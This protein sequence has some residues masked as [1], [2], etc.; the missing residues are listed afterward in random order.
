MLALLVL[1]ELVL[2]PSSLPLPLTWLNWPFEAVVVGQEEEKWI[3]SPLACSCTRSIDFPGACATSKSCM[4]GE[5]ETGSTR[6]RAA[7]VA[8]GGEQ[9]DN[10]APALLVVVNITAVGVVP[11]PLIPKSIP[12]IGDVALGI[13]EGGEQDEVDEEEDD[14]ERKVLSFMV[15]KEDDGEEDV[16]E[17]GLGDEIGQGE[18][19]NREPPL[20][21]GEDENPLPEG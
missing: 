13:E 7:E 15:V 1:P 14:K 20:P 19:N 21:H 2:F 3:K 16:E 6:V 4:A 8:E 5:E 17:G 12:G 10:T 18:L 11:P 9:E